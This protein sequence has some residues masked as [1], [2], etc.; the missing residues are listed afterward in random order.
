MKKFL[1]EFKDFIATGN[2]VEIAV[3]LILATA[4]GLVI[5]AFTDGIVMNLVAAI[6]GKP[7]FDDIRWKIS[8]KVQTTADGKEVNGT[9]LEIGAFI[10]TL[11]NLLIVGLVLFMLIKAYNKMRKPKAA[12][13]GP[14][15]VDLLTEIRDSLRARG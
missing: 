8:D 2:M 7:T 12:D 9:Y 13:A 4:V 14:S 6:V 3:G 1:S 15:E 10:T 11:I 5:K